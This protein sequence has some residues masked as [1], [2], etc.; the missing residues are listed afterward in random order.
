MNFLRTP[1]TLQ[2]ALV[3]AYILCCGEVRGEVRSKKYINFQPYDDKY[4]M[5][6]PTHFDGTEITASDKTSRQST[7][8]IFNGPLLYI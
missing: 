4:K 6:L 8:L 1:V 2:R 5:T 7:Y 3:C